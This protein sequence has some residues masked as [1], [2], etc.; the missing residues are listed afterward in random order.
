VPATCRGA[1]P[2]LGF[3]TQTGVLEP[4]VGEVEH[5]TIVF[6]EGQDV[7]PDNFGA[8]VLDNIVVNDAVVGRGAAET[9]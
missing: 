2:L 1:A 5:I 7:G 3:N 8:A 9:D 6:D 4:V